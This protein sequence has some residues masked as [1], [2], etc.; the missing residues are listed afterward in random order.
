MLL[1]YELNVYV[2]RF[3]YY[4]ESGDIFEYGFIFSTFLSEDSDMATYTCY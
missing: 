2:R 3:D 4:N 1:K